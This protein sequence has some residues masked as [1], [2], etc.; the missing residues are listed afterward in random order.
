MT[1]VQ[2][3]EKAG[4]KLYWIACA[5]PISLSNRRTL[6]ATLTRLGMK[7]TFYVNSGGH[8]WVNWRIYLNTFAPLLFK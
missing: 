5:T 1:R 7:H 4:Y 2:G 3:C 6:D 8:T